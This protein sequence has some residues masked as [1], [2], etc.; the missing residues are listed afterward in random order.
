[1]CLKMKRLLLI[2]SFLLVFYPAMTV[3]A[4]QPYEVLDAGDVFVAT[5]SRVE[6]RSATNARPPRVWLKVHEVLHGKADVERSPALWRPPFHGFDYG[7][8]NLPELKRWNAMP[9]KGPKVGV[10]MILGGQVLETAEGDNKV[11]EY[12][13]FAFV[14]IPF[15]EEARQQ[16]IKNLKVLA[17]AR[18][19]YAAEQAAAMKART[20]RARQWRTALHAKTIEK[21]TRIAD[22]VAI[23]KMVSG[24]TFEIERMLK[25]RPR[26]SSGGKYFVS[27]PGD[28]FDPRIADHLN[29]GRPRCVLFL[30]E[31]RLVVSVTS[32][33]ADLID[34]Y[35]GIVV[36]DNEAIEA[37]EAALEKHPAPKP[38]PVMV[39]SALDR[40]DAPAVVSAAR[41]TFEVVVSH[42][43]SAHGPKT[44]Q[45]VRD[46]IPMTSCLMMIDRGPQRHVKVVHIGR[47]KATTIYEETWAEQKP[48]AN[49]DA[50]LQTL[51]EQITE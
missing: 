2:S 46:T 31:Q 3:I 4:G 22:A 28:G 42:Q 12:A 15:S 19:K 17:E 18:G 37:V 11:A 30:S 13:L 25:G 45:H 44:I 33:H 16:T 5:I 43:F 38:R 26:M 27:L 21:S 32:V 39:I 6:D 48:K 35:E 50:M 36:A 51:A 8:D 41:A 47:T 29:E 20:L 23:G 1:M 10:K 14:R 24:S 9:L 40:N 49:I 7:D 34:P